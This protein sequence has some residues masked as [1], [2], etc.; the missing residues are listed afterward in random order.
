MMSY[1]QRHAAP[2]E[3]ARYAI[4]RRVCAGGS[5]MRMRMMRMEKNTDMN[6]MECL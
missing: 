6:I 5:V 2:D 1:M 3:Y 4:R